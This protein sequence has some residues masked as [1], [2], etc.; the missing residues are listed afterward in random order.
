VD[1][2]DDV[3]ENLQRLVRPALPGVDIYACSSAEEGLARLRVTKVDAIVSDY[4][5]PGADGVAFLRD[6]ESLAP[7]AKKFLLSGAPDQFLVESARGR[8]TMLTKPIDPALL[9]R[10]LRSTLAPKP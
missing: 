2:D 7:N 9:V 8:F 3:L 1:D 4:H 5:M 6:A 10:L